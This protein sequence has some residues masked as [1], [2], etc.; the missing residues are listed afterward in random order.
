MV[1]DAMIVSEADIETRY[2]IV[3]ASCHHKS[4]D[5]SVLF[6]LLLAGSLPT[7]IMQGTDLVA[8]S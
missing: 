4:G 3:A 1:S 2:H 6:R 5:S 8:L 7:T